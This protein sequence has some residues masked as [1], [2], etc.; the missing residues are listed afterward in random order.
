MSQKEKGRKWKPNLF[1]SSCSHT[2]SNSQR[3]IDSPLAASAMTITT[4]CALPAMSQSMGRVGSDVGSGNMGQ[5]G[6]GAEGQ[7][8]RGAEGQA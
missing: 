3:S 5:G 2:M 7:R 4:F 1:W 6:R 8:G